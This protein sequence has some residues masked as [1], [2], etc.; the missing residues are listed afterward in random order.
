MLAFSTDPVKANDASVYLDRNSS[1]VEFKAIGNPSALVI[2]GKGAGIEG[3]MQFSSNGSID[4][5]AI[6]DLTSLSTGIGL[7]DSHLKN[8][9]LDVEHHKHAEFKPQ[10]VYWRTAAD[11]YTQP[12]VEQPFS[13]LLKIRNIEKRIEGTMSSVPKDGK[14]ETTFKFTVSLQDFDIAIPSFAGITVAKDVEVKVMA[15]LRKEKVP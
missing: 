6:L 12:V 7:R 15:L 9:Y 14:A 5:K 2:L 10:K 8:K 4:G 13:G 3:E 11:V 1:F